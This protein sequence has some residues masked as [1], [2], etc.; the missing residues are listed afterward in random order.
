LSENGDWDQFGPD[1]DF[2]PYAGRPRVFVLAS[3]PRTGSHYLGH[4]LHATGDMGA[5]LEYL[6]CAHLAR[7]AEALGT[8]GEAKT[9]RA[10]MGRRT[11]PSGWFGLKAHWAQFQ[12]FAAAAEVQAALDVQGWIHITRADALDQAISLVIAKQSKAPISFR[13]V[14]AQPTYD[15]AAITAAMARLARDRDGWERFFAARGMQ[16]LRIAYDRLTAEPEAAVA[17]IRLRLGLPPAPSGRARPWM[18]QRQ[19]TARNA[20]WRARYLTETNE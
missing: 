16:P 8:D 12:P 18:P 19:A 10:L 13:A 5:P 7:W 3:S 1:Y 2:P 15:R 11:A 9:L 6:H 4:L 20:D 17:A 14:Q